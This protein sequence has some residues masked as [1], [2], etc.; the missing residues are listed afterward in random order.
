MWLCA[1][2]CAPR[3]LAASTSDLRGCL[4]AIVCMC[5]AARGGTYPVIDLV[6]NQT[7]SDGKWSTPF[8][9]RVQQVKGINKRCSYTSASS[10]VHDEDGYL[11][12]LVADVNTT[13]K[14]YDLDAAAFSASADYQAV[15]SGT[16]WSGK[17]YVAT[18]G[19]CGAYIANFAPNTTLTLS[20]QFRNAVTQLSPSD[21]FGAAALVKAFGTH[22]TSSLVLGGKT[23]FTYE[24]STSSYS[25]LTSS[26]LDVTA[27]ASTSYLGAHASL[28]PTSKHAADAKAFVKASMGMTRSVVGPAAPNTTLKPDG[29]GDSS[30]WQKLVDGNPFPVQYSLQSITQFLTREYFPQDPDI[31]TKQVQLG[32]Y[33]RTYCGEVENCAAKTGDDGFFE[34]LPALPK[35]WGTTAV[36][37]ASVVVGGK[38]WVL[39]GS[40]ATTN[41]AYF[42]VESDPKAWVAV[43][44]MPDARRCASAASAGNGSILV[45]GGQ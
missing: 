45:F 16:Q 15:K 9:F 6:I 20:N 29:S 14:G 40:P 19:V 34:Q 25:A 5:C 37:A 26:G 28:P 22:I 35:D 7:S 17:V 13:G 33:L 4:A 31:V 3:P 10:T 24:F 23:T 41:A 18:S 42:D 36:C 8:G 43:P 39:G 27:G 11:K 32:K 38:L 21:Q 2:V 30:G 44:P 1:R 12:S